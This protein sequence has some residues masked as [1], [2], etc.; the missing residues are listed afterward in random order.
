MEINNSNPYKDIPYTDLTSHYHKTFKYFKEKNAYKKAKKLLLDKNICY[1]SIKD[2]KQID[3]IVFYHIK[4]ELF[5]RRL[6]FKSL[7]E[8]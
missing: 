7:K 4:P 5:R 2:P 1:I 8:I 6:K 3:K